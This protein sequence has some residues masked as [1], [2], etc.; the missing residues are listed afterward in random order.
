MYWNKRKELRTSPHTLQDRGDN[1]RRLSTKDTQR[2]RDQ[3]LSPQLEIEGQNGSSPTPSPD[4]HMTSTSD[5]PTTNDSVIP[6]L[7]DNWTK[8]ETEVTIKAN[9]TTDEYH[10][11]NSRTLLT[12]GNLSTISWTTT[13]SSH[14][15]I[16]P[17]VQEE[18]AALEEAGTRRDR[19]SSRN[20]IINMLYLVL[21]IPIPQVSGI[22]RY[23]RYRNSDTEIRYFC[24]IGYRYRIHRDV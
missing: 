6:D 3:K 10:P 12:T 13:I 15:N 23:L 4:F 2:I 19:A 18:Y 22:G 16:K 17:S 9:K 7:R 21:S 8:N 24:G 1:L 5:V 11:A 20:E 14:V